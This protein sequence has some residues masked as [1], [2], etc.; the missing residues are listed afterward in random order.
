MMWPDSLAYRVNAIARLKGAFT[1]RSGQI[2]TEY[3]DKY[4]RCRS[5][6]P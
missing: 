1:L 6:R 4:R 2:S 5:P 3:F